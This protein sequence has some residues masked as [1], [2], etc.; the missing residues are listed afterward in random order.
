MAMFLA[1]DIN[2]MSFGV[3]A[4]NVSEVAQ[5]SST[6]DNVVVRM[7][8]NNG[9]ATDNIMSGVAIGSSNYDKT[10]SA[11]NNLFFGHITGKSNITPVML[12]QSGQIAINTVPASNYSLTVTGGVDSDAITTP[13]LAATNVNDTFRNIAATAYINTATV[14]RPPA[15]APNGDTQLTMHLNGNSTQY[16]YNLSVSSNNS[17]VWSSN[18]TIAGSTSSVLTTSIVHAF[19]KGVYNVHLGVNTSIAGGSGT[20]S[21]FFQSNIT[22]FSVNVTDTI[23][24]PTI[25]LAGTPVFSTNHYTTV[26]GLNYY[27]K[28]TTVTFPA[29]SI[30]FTNIYGVLPPSIVSLTTPLSINGSNYSYTDVFTDA[31]TNASS[32]TAAAGQ[33]IV[34]YT[35]GSNI[36]VPATVYNVNYTG[37]RGVT[38]P[39]FLSHIGYLDAP[40]DELH[41]QMATFSGLP[42]SSVVRSSVSAISPGPNYSVA[43][44]TSPFTLSGNDLYYSPF[45]SLLV[46]DVSGVNRGTY[47][48]S[49]TVSGNRPYV[50]LTV[51]TTAPLS[52]FVLNLARSSGLS[53][54]FVKWTTLGSTWYNATILSTDTTSTP[55]CAASTL[56]G[57]IS[58]N[59][60]FPI[61][62]PASVSLTTSS[63]INIVISTTAYLDVS[64]ISLSYT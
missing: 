48:P 43:P 30:R 1:D 17:T 39:N 22:N 34:L 2:E 14:D 58:N 6:L 56:T 28:G 49:T 20:G 42:I 59:T 54:V 60:R 8:T 41:M 12:M 29:N 21:S 9:A 31:S 52:A 45:D 26:S 25:A 38:S 50:C 16:T 64:G 19:E 46:P 36:S 51:T 7:F 15:S 13:W 10:A 37:A 3:Q 27:T 5:F 23:A 55:G 35:S 62:L 18:A 40:I 47:N 24:A 53:S 61:T 63:P 57:S 4:S 33:T 32:N 44:Y 11:S